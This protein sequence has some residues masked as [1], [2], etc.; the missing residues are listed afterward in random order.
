MLLLLLLSFVCGNLAASFNYNRCDKTNGPSG[1][2]GSCKDNENTPINLCGATT[3]PNTYSPGFTLANW[4]VQRQ[5]SIINPGYTIQVNVLDNHP[6]LQAGSLAG[7]VGRGK[8]SSNHLWVLAQ[9]H[10]HV[11]RTGK[12]NEGSEHYMQGRAYPMEIHFVHYNSAIASS[13]SSAVGTGLPEALL[14]V[15]I[16]IEVG[17]EGDTLTKMANAI[18][19][20]TATAKTM[21]G[22]VNFNDL[23]DGSG[24]YYSYAGGLTTPGCNQQVT[25]VVMKTTKTISQGTLDKYKQA[26][27]NPSAVQTSKFLVQADGVQGDYG[28]FRPIQSTNGRKVY[29]SNGDT[30]KCGTVTEPNYNCNSG[31]LLNNP[32]FLL[33]LMA[34]GFWASQL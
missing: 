32:S 12:L 1:W 17:A 14:V 21:P 9:M 10:V 29:S 24:A 5:V 33:M 20:T 22:T 27:T 3:F 26:T 19:N 15:G 31:F 18:S 6:T 30:D 16:F 13:V 7:V 25:W 8:N 23:F 28:T 11:G 2:G 4:N 34:V